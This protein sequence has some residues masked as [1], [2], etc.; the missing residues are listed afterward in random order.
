MTLN[1]LIAICRERV[2]D[3][4]EPY[5]I[6][7]ELWTIYAAHAQ[8]QAAERALLLRREFDIPILAGQAV[9]A[10]P[11]TWL[12]TFRARL[13]SQPS[14]LIK[15]TQREL[16]RYLHNWEDS[17]RTPRYFFE[18]EH[19]LRLYP[20]PIADD[21]LLLFAYALPESTADDFELEL[22]PKDHRYLTHW[23]CYEVLSSWEA[24]VYNPEAAERELALFNLRFGDE[25]NANQLRHWRELPPNMT[26]VP[27]PMV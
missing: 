21:V 15:T 24:D 1:E 13:L 11:E 18:Y 4:V 19:E 25:R 3:T 26:V 17:L 8:K 14:P 2:D 7:D 6:S 23:M 27:R 9:Y 16:D 20:T 22:E 12:A 10:L 5:F